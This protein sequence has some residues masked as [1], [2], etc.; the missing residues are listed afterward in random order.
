MAFTDALK[1]MRGKDYSDGKNKGMDSGEPNKTP[2][3]IKL[4]DEEMKGFENSKPGEDLACE[5][6]GSLE[7]DG[8][9][10][11]M[12]VGPMN[13]SYGEDENKMAG[14]VAQKVTPT[15]QLSPS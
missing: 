13:G 5:V 2:R 12:T 8:H 7:E 14:E 15:V 11:V 10:H 6:H 9:F 1:S 3:I 4:S